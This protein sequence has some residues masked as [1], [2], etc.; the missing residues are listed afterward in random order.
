MQS[1]T[2]HKQ[3]PLDASWDVI[4]VGGG[5]AGCTAAVAAAREGAKTL[6]LEATECLGGMS[7]SGLVPTWCPFSDGERILYQGL[8]QQVFNRLKEQ[9]PHVPATAANWVP[10]DAEALKQ[11]YDSMVTEAGATVLFHTHLCDAEVDD[12]GNVTSIIVANKGGLKAY[13]AQ[14][15]VDCTGD[16][17]LIAYAGAP[18]HKGDD[19]TGELQPGSH[20]FV[21]TNVDDYGYLNGPWLNRKNPQS[22]IHP[23][24]AS[25]EYPLIDDAHLCSKQVGPGAVGFNAGHVYD[26]DSTDPESLS[27]ALIKGR[28]I[29]AQLTAGL[30]QMHPTAFGNAL[31]TKTGSLMGIRE[32]RRI[33]GD[34]TLTVE[35]YAQRRSFPDE[36]CRN[37]YSIDIHGAEHLVEKY[38]D[39]H[40]RK[41]ESHGIP[42]RCLAPKDLQNVLVAGRSISSDRI[43]NGSVRVMPVCLAMG[44][45]AGLA[46]ALAV[47]T[48]AGNV[49]QVDPNA[50]RERLREEGAYLP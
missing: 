34:Y 17:D 31:L 43:V 37:N 23:I 20:C 41:G 4:V 32:S 25:A 6:L 26:V 3:L 22:P 50:L 39:L 8:A 14:V 12:E 10:I 9:M 42:Y 13:R 40:Y 35:D 48:V 47:R 33:I 5:P 16:A 18:F 24:V 44:E 11:L 36:I 45:A 19:K 21:L 2:L 27:K 1:Y 38:A 15:Y 28:Q 29:A 30:R 49:H 7:T 46:A